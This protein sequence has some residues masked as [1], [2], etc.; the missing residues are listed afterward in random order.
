MFRRFL[1]I[2]VCLCCWVM[3][4]A[5]VDRQT[6]PA[7][8]PAKLLAKKPVAVVCYGDSITAGS[9]DYKWP[10]LLQQQLDRSAAGKFQV[11]NRGFSGETSVGAFYRLR[12]H[13]FPLMPAIVLIEFGINDASSPYWGDQSRVNLDEYRRKMTGIC[14]AIRA[15]GGYPVFIIN[16]PLKQPDLSRVQGDEARVKKVTD[17]WTR[18][19]NGQNPADTLAIY[20]NTVRDIAARLGVPTIDLPALMAQRN[21]VPQD[22]LTDDGIHLSP[23][24]FALYAEMVHEG[25]VTMVK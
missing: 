22:I 24:G 7:A 9:R 8:C 19:G 15:Q 13:I 25:F 2:S 4:C 10:D 11:I 18:P 17:T 20:N 14:Q 1:L 23:K 6:P 21:L 3:G 12:D 16:H 5:N